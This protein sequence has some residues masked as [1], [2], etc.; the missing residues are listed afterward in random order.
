MIQISAIIGFVIGAFILHSQQ[1]EI[2]SLS[3]Y[4]AISAF[5]GIPTTLSR[6]LLLGNATAP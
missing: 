2:L 5:L 3:I 1:V 6:L 4:L